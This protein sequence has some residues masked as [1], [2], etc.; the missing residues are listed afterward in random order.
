VVGGHTEV[1]PGLKRPIVVGFMVGVVER[2][3]FVTSSGARPNQD[4]ILT[5]SVGIEGTAV[6]AMDF[7]RRLECDDKLLARARSM[8]HSVSIVEDA[9]I[10][11]GVGGVHAMHD[12]TEGGVLQGIWEIA[13][14]SKVGFVVD[15]SKIA[16][17]NE[18]NLICRL[19]HVDPLRLMS[20]GCLLLAAENRKS[21]L[22]IRR[23]KQKGI[24]A[25][26]IGRFTDR[27]KGRKLVRLNGSTTEIRASER[28]ELYR[29]IETL[30][31]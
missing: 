12:P 17:R 3:K 28:D 5:K 21:G 7:A 19:L 4:L 10:A 30:G 14:A 18:T 6:L 23:L 16:I 24:E 8:R 29:V 27:K 9:M 15:E 26:I 13:E 20:S 31:N 11:V 25:R 2:K 22:M 1:T